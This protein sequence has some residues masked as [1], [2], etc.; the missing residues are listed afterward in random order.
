MSLWEELTSRPDLSA[1]QPVPA[2]AVRGALVIV[3]SLLCALVYGSSG[4]LYVGVIFALVAAWQP[5]FLLAWGLIVFIGLGELGHRDTLSWRFLVLLAGVQL[6]HTLAQ[7]S[8]GLPWRAWIELAVFR[9]PLERFIATQIPVQ[10]VA[11]VALLL[12][13]PSRH[14]HRPV[15][16][17]EFAVLGALALGGLALL[18]LRDSPG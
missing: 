15:T 12:L 2:L 17:A 4:W 13:A 1:A 11:V 16:V 18:L 7:L 3:A 8:L 5:E 10:I 6:L 14:G 9:R